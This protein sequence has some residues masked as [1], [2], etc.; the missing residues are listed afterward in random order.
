MIL[1]LSA[2]TRVKAEFALNIKIVAIIRRTDM[3][4]FGSH[5]L[6]PFDFIANLT[7][8]SHFKSMCRFIQTP[9]FI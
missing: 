8:L 1:F 2:H 5:P 4:R 9:E 7:L 3:F 6:K